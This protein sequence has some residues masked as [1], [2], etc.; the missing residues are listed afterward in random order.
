MARTKIFVSHS[1]KDRDWLGKLEEHVAV[2]VRR[3]LVDFWADTQIGPGDIWKSEIEAKLTD[4]KVAVLLV[5]PAFLAS[6][7]I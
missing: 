6:K 7:F 4:A 1:H 5:S 3:D 2:L